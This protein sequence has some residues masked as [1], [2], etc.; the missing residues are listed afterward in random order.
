MACCGTSGRGVACTEM[1]GRYSVVAPRVGVR[2]HDASRSSPGLGGAGGRAG[3]L[4]GGGICLCGLASHGRVCSALGLGLGL[5][6]HSRPLQ[7]TRRSR[8]GL[9]K[10][11]NVR[12]LAGGPSAE[13]AGRRELWSPFAPT[14][15]STPN[16]ER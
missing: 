9:A 1:R 7:L 6:R 15:T 8:A 16:F 14:S 3:R 10:R 12:V 4:A 2:F 5:G 11:K 13:I